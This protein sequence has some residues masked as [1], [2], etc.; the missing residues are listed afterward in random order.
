M[1]SYRVVLAGGREHG[2]SQA[3]NPVTFAKST[4]EVLDLTT[5]TWSYPSAE[6]NMPYTLWGMGYARV[7]EEV[8]TAGVRVTHVIIMLRTCISCTQQVTQVGYIG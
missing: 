4:M 6:H 2:L 7:G 8:F 5:W 1:P 3:G